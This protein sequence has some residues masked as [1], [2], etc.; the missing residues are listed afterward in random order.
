MFRG[1]V[2]SST[3]LIMYRSLIH[4]LVSL[5]RRKHTL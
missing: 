5:W 1:D 2:I 3:L 4:D